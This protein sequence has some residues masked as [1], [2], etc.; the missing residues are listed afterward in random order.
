[1]GDTTT[2]E[3][4]W[5]DVHD[6][7]LRTL[8]PDDDERYARLVQPADRNRLAIGR[9]LLRRLVPDAR[10]ERRCPACA[11]AEHGPPQPRDSATRVSISHCADRVV[12]AITRSSGRA[13]PVGVDVESGSAPA[14]HDEAAMRSVLRPSELAAAGSGDAARLEPWWVRKE[15]VLKALG[16]G[17]TVELRDLEVSR[18]GDSP[19]LLAWDTPHPLPGQV[20]MR[21]LD[22]GAGHWCCLAVV[23]EE[24]THLEV[25]APQ[26]L[27]IPAS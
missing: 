1:M 11:S 27:E 19:E 15:A 22:V 12:V 10:W 18:P 6:V 16:L 21:D 5:S 4:A 14:W 26:R 24:S 23:V 20:L 13:V 7:P 17:L 8:L 3:I 9:A 2:C 25:A